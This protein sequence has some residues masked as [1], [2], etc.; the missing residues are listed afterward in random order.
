M[1]A[2]LRQ[3]LNVL[4][5]AVSALNLPEALDQFDSWFESGEQHYVCVCNVHG[6]MEC[7]KS[8]ALKR[9]FNRAGLVTPDGMPLVWLLRHA[10]YKKASRVYGPDLMMAELR[11]A[12][13]HAR[14][15]Y[16]YGGAA[17]VAGQL[18]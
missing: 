15:H 6:I 10:G 3:P 18:K 16:F 14:T 8:N 13:A 1:P 12:P 17:G 7:Q 11:R 4:G 9:M 2:G 5:V